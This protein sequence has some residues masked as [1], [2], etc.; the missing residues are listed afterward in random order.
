MSSKNLRFL[1]YVNA[2]NIPFVVLRLK[3]VLP[4]SN[5]RQKSYLL[6]G[7]GAGAYTAEQMQKFVYK[8]IWL[9]RSVLR[10]AATI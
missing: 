9:K 7:I 10:H 1:D 8:Q 5:M 6:I 3:F 2:F 4:K